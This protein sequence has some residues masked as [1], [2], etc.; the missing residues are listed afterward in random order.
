MALRIAAVIAASML[1]VACVRAKPGDPRAGC[2]SCHAPHYAE[3]GACA[4]CH[5]GQPAAAR[6]ELAHARLLSGRAAGYLL[7]N[8]KAVSEG[9]HLVDIASCRRCHTIGGKGNTLATNLDNVVW[10]RE[11]KEL[12]GSITEPVENMPVFGFDG[13]QTEALVAFLLSGAQ[14][15]P[16][17][18]TYRVQFTREEVRAPS[19][20]DEKCGGCHRRL[21]PLG[22]EGSRKDG[23]NLSGLLTDFY[24]GTAPGDRPWSRKALAA[25]IANP[26]EFRP[27]TLMPPVSMNEDEIN[28]VVDRAGEAGVSAPPSSR[29]GVIR[30]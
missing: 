5:R 18:E 7:A 25:W 28:Q 30:R 8:G 10:N 1:F 2:S 21:T 11:Q 29:V 22:P 27:G 3:V 16:A 17:E 12:M 9:R 20:F 14:L 6:K 13:G 15:N 26:R 19:V 23:P 4:E 24:P